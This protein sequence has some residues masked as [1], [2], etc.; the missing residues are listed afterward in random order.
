MNKLESPTPMH[1]CFVPSL[2]EIG[3]VILEKKTKTWKIYSNKN[4]DRQQ[5]N[6]N[7]RLKVHLSIWLSLAKNAV[8]I[9]LQFT[10]LSQNVLLY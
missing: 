2:V 5:T 4:D 3:P 9:I 6:F 7:Q 8:V 1:R 10:K